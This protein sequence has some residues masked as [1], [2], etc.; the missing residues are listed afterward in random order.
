MFTGSELKIVHYFLLLTCACT[1]ICFSQT[2]SQN[3]FLILAVRGG[4]A[5]APVAVEQSSLTAEKTD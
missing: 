5:A 1:P 3:C 2:G 4:K